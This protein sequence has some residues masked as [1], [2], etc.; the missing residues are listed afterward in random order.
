MPELEWTAAVTLMEKG[1]LYRT[2]GDPVERWPAH[3]FRYYLETRRPHM[4]PD[5][6][7]LARV[8]VSGEWVDF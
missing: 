8:L 4:P 1:K 5:R 6:A 3:G 2:R 7:H